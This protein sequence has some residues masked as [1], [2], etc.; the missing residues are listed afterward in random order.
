MV[1]HSSDEG[2]FGTVCRP[3]DDCGG[4]EVAR[5]STGANGCTLSSSGICGSKM[6]DTELERLSSRNLFYPCSG[7]DVNQPIEECWNDV[8]TFGLSTL[9]MMVYQDLCS[10]RCRQ[11][12]PKRNEASWV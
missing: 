1:W 7:R 10:P 2:V 12:D 11:N 8:G 9:D 6:M 3:E 5:G 4:F